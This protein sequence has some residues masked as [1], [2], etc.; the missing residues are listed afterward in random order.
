MRTGR[1]LLPLTLAV[2]ALVAMCWSMGAH[3]VGKDVIT[4]KDIIMDGTN[5]HLPVKVADRSVAYPITKVLTR[6]R[7]AGIARTVLSGPAGAAAT[8]AG[9]VLLDYNSDSGTGSMSWNSTENNYYIG[10]KYNGSY[11]DALFDGSPTPDCEGAPSAILSCHLAEMER[12]NPTYNYSMTGGYTCVTPGTNNSCTKIQWNMETRNASTNAFVGNNTRDMNRLT[13]ATQD[14]TVAT[15]DQVAD[16][17]SSYDDL[18]GLKDMFAEQI[19]NDILN[20]AA[21]SPISMSQESIDQINQAVRDGVYTGLDSFEEEMARWARE[22]G[23][24]G[25]PKPSTVPEATQD[26]EGYSGGGTQVNP[27]QDDMASGGEE[28]TAPPTCSGQQIQCMQV[29]Q[30]WRARC[31]SQWTDEEVMAAFNF[32]DAE[33]GLEAGPNDGTFLAD[34]LDD[35]AFIAGAACPTAPSFTVTVAGQSKTIDLDPI[36]EPACFMAEKFAPFVV[37]MAYFASALLLFRE[38]GGA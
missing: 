7:V 26:E 13:T 19:N 23:V 1:R 36:W 29:M 11:Q 24:Q 3:A 31:P 14:S 28:C 35:T 8:I 34:D 15:D 10:E 32:S 38:F 25:V 16:A 21:H 22:H 5:M 17:F 20:Q 2:I 27:E 12:L 33:K 4:Y 30:A 6:A 37:A 18:N 9:L